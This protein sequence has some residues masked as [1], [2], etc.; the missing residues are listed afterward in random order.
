MKVPMPTSQEIRE[1]VEFL[2]RLHAEGFT[3]SKKWGGRTNIQDSVFT[4]P[5]PEY[6][7]VVREFFR[8]ASRECWIDDE[9]CPEDAAQMLE[10]D[11]FVETADLSQIKTML[12]YCVRGE[13]FC[14][15][16]WGA[17][18]EGGYVCRLLQRL[19]VLGSTNA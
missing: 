15:G 7:D 6:D 16:H 18:I 14:D 12:T 1:L 8:V 13:R 4:M 5:L 19:A 11:I 2:P 3:P 10:N 17:M 9:Y